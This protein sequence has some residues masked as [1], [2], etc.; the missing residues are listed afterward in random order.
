MSKTPA[1]RLIADNPP[2]S[3][4][5]AS[6]AGELLERADTGIEIGPNGIA[7]MAEEFGLMAREAAVLERGASPGMLRLAPGGLKGRIK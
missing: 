1:L 5:L 6:I 4:R 3:E 2:L 7:V